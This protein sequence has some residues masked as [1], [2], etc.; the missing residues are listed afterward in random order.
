MAM[1]YFRALADLYG[2]SLDT[3]VRDLP[4]KILDI[5]LYGS[6][7]QDHHRIRERP[8]KGGSIRPSLRA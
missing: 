4:P 8:W 6:N 5:L 7:G 1:S 3:P 2:F